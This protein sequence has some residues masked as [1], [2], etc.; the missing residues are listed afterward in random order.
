[1]D[2]PSEIMD[3]GINFSRV[4]NRINTRIDKITIILPVSNK[5]F[6]NGKSQQGYVL[7]AINDMQNT[8]RYLIIRARRLG[9]R[10]IRGITLRLKDNIK[11]YIYV[12]CQPISKHSEFMRLD[13]SPQHWNINQL[14]EALMFIFNA[15]HKRS[16]SLLRK[17]YI[18]RID[19]A[20]DIDGHVMSDV[21]VDYDGVRNGHITTSTS[22]GGLKLGAD[23]SRICL[24]VYEKF[25]FIGEQEPEMNPPK[26]FRVKETDVHPFTRFEIR[27][28]P[29]KHEVPLSEL[30]AIENLASSLHL[31]D[32]HAVLLRSRTHRCFK[33]AIQ[34]MTLPEVWQTHYPNTSRNLKMRLR[35]EKMQKILSSNELALNTDMIWAS[36]PEC[37][38]KL[39]L[40][41]QPNLWNEC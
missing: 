15:I 11:C 25:T 19:F 21:I 7:Q 4:D 6:S 20:I 18:S 29:E 35:K 5:V 30:K 33:T 32:R 37:V 28:S 24:P 17:A 23:T 40:L 12:E 1:M 27:F 8:D 38:S 31:Y 41:A 26:M 14:N 9:R 34:S 2:I 3:Q 16:I 10:Y 36:W 22:F 13:L 39:G